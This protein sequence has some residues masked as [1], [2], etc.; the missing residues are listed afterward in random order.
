MSDID[1]GERTPRRLWFC[2]ALVA[3]ALHAGGAAW[4]L[5]D[6]KGGDDDGGL[7]ASGA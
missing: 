7:G 4:A 5:A 1:S 3:L 2:A 6:L